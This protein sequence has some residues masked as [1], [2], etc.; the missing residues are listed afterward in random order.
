M[1][2]S[3]LTTW[4]DM[5]YSLVSLAG[6]PGGRLSHFLG[7]SAPELSS[8]MGGAWRKSA[9]PHIKHQGNVTLSLPENVSPSSCSSSR[10]IIALLKQEQGAKIGFEP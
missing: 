4:A 9:P 3:V 10:T 5:H 7:S 2:L 8:L 1:S 6:P